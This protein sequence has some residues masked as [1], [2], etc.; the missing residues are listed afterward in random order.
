MEKQL[1]QE[2]ERVCTLFFGDLDLF[3]KSTNEKEKGRL[4][5]DL[6][7]LTPLARNEYGCKNPVYIKQIRNLLPSYEVTHLLW[8]RLLWDIHW[9]ENL[10]YQL[11]NHPIAKRVVEEF[12]QKARIVVD[13]ADAVG[14]GAFDEMEEPFFKVP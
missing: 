12:W 6:A 1:Y 9:A 14:Y 8:D 3:S 2:F 10:C 7:R 5:D 4:F 11:D 13:A